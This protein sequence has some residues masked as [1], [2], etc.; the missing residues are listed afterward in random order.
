M[1][2]EVKSSDKPVI[3][4]EK[5]RHAVQVLRL[6]QLYQH[7]KKVKQDDY[8]YNL[9]DVCVESIRT[10]RDREELG[11]ILDKVRIRKFEP[12]PGTVIE[13][14]DFWLHEPVPRTVLTTVL[15]KQVVEDGFTKLNQVIDI[16]AHKLDSLT[17]YT[18][19]TCLTCRTP[20]TYTRWIKLRNFVKDFIKYLVDSKVVKL[21][22]DS[23]RL[24]VDSL[25]ELLQWSI[26]KS[27]HI[28][29]FYIAVTRRFLI[30]GILSTLGEVTEYR[31]KELIHDLNKVVHMW[32]KG[33]KIDRDFEVITKEYIYY[34]HVLKKDDWYV[35]SKFKPLSELLIEV[36]KL[37]IEDD[38]VKFIHDL[39]KDVKAFSLDILW[40]LVHVTDLP[41]E[42]KVKLFEVIKSLV[43]ELVKTSDYVYIQNLDVIVDGF[44]LKTLQKLVNPVSIG[45]AL[46]FIS[47]IYK[48][49]PLSK[50]SLDVVHVVKHEVGNVVDELLEKIVIR[51]ST[52]IRQGVKTIRATILE[53]LNS[54]GV[55][56][57]DISKDIVEVIDPNALKA[58]TVFL[59]VK[60]LPYVLKK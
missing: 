27:I 55:V 49:L 28:S 14:P 56:K 22:G 10:A 18:S 40:K 23:I 20:Y 41:N 30:L 21:S 42:K 17:T 35:W 54:A 46:D 4:I 6:L 15:F 32:D 29:P 25:S 33:D 51:Y 39:F 9:V 48:H 11:K 24:E 59:S 16:V 52:F 34:L 43:S 38:V 60:P 5:P 31:I 53:L 45:Q 58:I 8:V 13:F 47:R 3:Y 44:T 26:S 37:G 1:S 12:K 57:Y 7:L 36:K 50:E 2:R 19:S